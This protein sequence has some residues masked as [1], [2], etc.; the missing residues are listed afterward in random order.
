MALFKLKDFIPDYHEYFNNDDILTFDLYAGNEKVGSIDNL[1]VDEKGQF[2]YFLINT[3]NWIFGK[4]VLLP[5]GYARVD[6]VERLVCADTL[7][8]E[9]VEDLPE[10][11][12]DMTV[13]FDHEE[14]VRK[15]Y[16]SH[17]QKT[18]AGLGVGYGGSDSAPST[19][20]TTPGVDLS[21]GYDGY[22]KDTYNYELDADLY[23]LSE[24]NNAGLFSSQERMRLRR[25]NISKPARD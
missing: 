9:Q 18:P 19:S 8:K 1:L 11:S 16:R 20:N 5:V 13:D 14:R 7:T 24:G 12:D 21:V 22:D 25:Q 23:D 3:G 4:K 10:Y 6:Y 17:R 2:R 15:V